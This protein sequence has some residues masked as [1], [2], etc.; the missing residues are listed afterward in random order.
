MDQE[1]WKNSNLE[2]QLRQVRAMLQTAEGKALLSA[3]TRDGGRAMA[4]ASERLRAGDAA[5]AK[6]AMEQVLTREEIQALNQSSQEG[7]WKT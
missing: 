4:K 7:P 6:Q 2:D 3:L 5:G 1:F